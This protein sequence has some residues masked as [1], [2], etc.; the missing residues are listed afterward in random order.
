MMTK[1]NKRD[2]L[3]K[4]EVLAMKLRTRPHDFI[5]MEGVPDLTAVDVRLNRLGKCLEC[6]VFLIKYGKDGDE[7]TQV[8]EPPYNDFLRYLNECHDAFDLGR[9]PDG[10]KK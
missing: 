8:N 4:L 1:L 7:L 9:K 5:C 3:Q 10:R 6:A 2:I